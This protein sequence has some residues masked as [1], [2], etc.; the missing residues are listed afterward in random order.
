MIVWWTENIPRRLPQS[1]PRELRSPRKTSNLD[2]TW[3]DLTIFLRAWAPLSIID[4][5][6]PEPKELRDWSWGSVTPGGPANFFD[7]KMHLWIS[8]CYIQ[9]YFSERLRRG[10]QGKFPN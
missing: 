5:K 7:A 8:P 1:S 6:K 3:V 9:F 4:A 10:P 2:R